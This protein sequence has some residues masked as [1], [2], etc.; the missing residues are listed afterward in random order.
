MKHLDVND[1]LIP[2]IKELYRSAFPR[3]EQ[4]PFSQ[5]V[6]LGQQDD[7]AF[8]AL[9]D[10]DRWIGFT[11]CALYKKTIYCMYLAVTP[12][13]RNQ[14]YGSKI[15]DYLQEQFPQDNLLGEIEI[16]DEQ[17]DN[18]DQR[19]RRRD[20]YMRHGFHSTHYQITAFDMT[21]EIIC[22]KDS[23]STNTYK[24]LVERLH[25]F[26]QVPDILPME[27]KR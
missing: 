24:E 22:T 3:Q 9:Y 10:H 5:L 14:G 6:K 2:Q 13:L 1:Q 21:Y 19:K 25:L 8:W 17:A 16:L 27:T 23:F 11:H 7:Y 20:F 18:N 26:K 15:L 12:D 4:M